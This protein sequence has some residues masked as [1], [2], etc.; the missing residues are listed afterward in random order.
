MLPKP[1]TMF[2]LKLTL[3]IIATLATIVCLAG[4]QLTGD[5]IYLI[6]SAAN[7]YGLVTIK[8]LQ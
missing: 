4:F 5:C 7:L 2:W 3:Y 8:R 6:L 1:A